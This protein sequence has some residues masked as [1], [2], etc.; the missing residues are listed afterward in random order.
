MREWSTADKS[1][2]GNGPWQ[3]EPDK[4][5]WTDAAT[6]L[7]CLIVRG[8]SGALCGYVG[9][10]DTHPLHGKSYH[11]ANLESHGGLTFSDPCSPHDDETIQQYRR[12]LP[13][14]EAQAKT[15]PHGDS[16]AWLKEFKP[17]LDDPQ[18]FAEHIQASRVCHIPEPGEPDN[19]W[20]FGF[21]CAHAFDFCPAFS[22]HRPVYSDEVYRDIN[23]VTAEVTNLA[24]QLKHFQEIKNDR[25]EGDN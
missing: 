22:K 17:L 21:D 15:Y 6:E 7:P 23:Y 2:W 11:D 5:Q 4:R 12:K 20:W 16:A 19:V 24:H 1:D 25:P 8:P 3:S 18:K 9:V 13:M 10:P 14:H